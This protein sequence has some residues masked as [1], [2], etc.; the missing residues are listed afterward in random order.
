M[1]GFDSS[2]FHFRFFQMHHSSRGEI[3]TLIL[4]FCFSGLNM[5]TLILWYMG[6][7]P[8]QGAAKS[9]LVSLLSAGLLSG[10]A[11]HEF[12]ALNKEHWRGIHMIFQNKY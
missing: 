11:T 6:H 5:P 9:L 4:L 8:K 12:M 3:L 2:L 1:E 10:W 7:L